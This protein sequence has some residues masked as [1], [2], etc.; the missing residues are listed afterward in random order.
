[1]YSCSWMER[2]GSYIFGIKI[3]FSINWHLTSVQHIRTCRCWFFISYK[4]FSLVVC[5]KIV[6][7]VK[8]GLY[9]FGFLKTI[10]III[11]ISTVN[12]G[13]RAKHNKRAKIIFSIICSKLERKKFDW[14]LNLIPDRWALHFFF[15]Y[16][17]RNLKTLLV[18]F[19]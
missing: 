6:Y 17:E 8:W 2:A 18:S 5:G 14:Q 19:T 16:W 15:Y 1:M 10:W 9:L 11:V 13:V 3:T 7:L 4:V 12:K